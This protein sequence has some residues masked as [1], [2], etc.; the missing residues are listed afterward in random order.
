M[1]GV[2]LRGRERG[3][4]MEVHGC[5]LND[6]VMLEGEGERGKTMSV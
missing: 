3:K 6:W 4:T 1:N 2:C 5:L